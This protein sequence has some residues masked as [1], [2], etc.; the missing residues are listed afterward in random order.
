MFVLVLACACACVSV[1]VCIYRECFLHRKDL[2]VS[3]SQ[4]P[5]FESEVSQRLSTP[6]VAVGM[7][8]VQQWFGAGNM[9]YFFNFS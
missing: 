7:C 2:Y 8:T 4:P 6:G 5:I 9:L 3:C 1:C